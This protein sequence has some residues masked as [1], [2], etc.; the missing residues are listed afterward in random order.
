[1]SSEERAEVQLVNG[2]IQ[3][4]NGTHL[5][6][7]L[8]YVHPSNT[9]YSI[10]WFSEEILDTSFP[11]CLLN[12]V[13]ISFAA[14]MALPWNNVFTCLMAKII[15]A[16]FFRFINSTTNLSVARPCQFIYETCFEF[17]T[18]YPHYY[19][20]SLSHHYFSPGLVS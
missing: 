7:I 4:Q 19:F 17:I 6:S 20:F 9:L 8:K 2:V 16:I 18:F 3:V 12:F 10:L 5:Y 14:I 13:H 1:M 15:S 11:I